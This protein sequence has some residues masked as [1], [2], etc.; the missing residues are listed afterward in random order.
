MNLVT[1]LN[2]KGAQVGGLGLQSHFPGEPIDLGRAETNINRY[3]NT[4]GLPIWA[5]EFTW[6]NPGG[7]GGDHSAHA[8]ELENYYRLLMSLQGIEVNQYMNHQT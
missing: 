4:F 8:E 3:W 2:N 6:R 1:E 5:T 7:A